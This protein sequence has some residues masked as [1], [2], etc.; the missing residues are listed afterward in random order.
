M[1]TVLIALAL[2]S[3]MGASSAARDIRSVENISEPVDGIE[4]LSVN[5]VAFADFSYRT[6]EGA[7]DFRFSIV[8]IVHTGDQEEF[9]RVAGR[10]EVTI[11]RDGS[12]L[13]C[14]FRNPKLR[15]WGF[16][17]MLF[18]VRKWEYE[19]EIT[20]PSETD[21]SLDAA[22]S[23]VDI[24][25]MN[26]DLDADI[27]FSGMTVLDHHGKASAD[28]AFSNLEAEKLDGTFDI[29]M[30]FSSVK[31]DIAK[32]AGNS[33]VNAAFGSA[34]FLLPEDTDADFNLTRAFGGIDFDLDR[35]PEGS[36]SHRTI[37]RG[38]NR[39]DMEVAFGGMN[40]RNR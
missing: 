30:A 12:A 9:D 31:V 14:K 16:L 13:I 17:R 35:D 37:G 34:K 8:R 24:R 39:I 27:A 29:T 21:L 3:C 6:V 20:G 18:H 26:G 15:A 19:I 36:G 28:I 40:V 33:R 10:M 23:D 4:I 25:G 11:K 1:R 38:G 2:V 22:F 32:L 7:E 5:G